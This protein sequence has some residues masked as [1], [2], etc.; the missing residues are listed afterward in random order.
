MIRIILILSLSFIISNSFAQVD[1]ALVIAKEVKERLNKGANFCEMVRLYSED[2]QTKAN[3]GELG[4]FG[5]GQL[6]RPYE[7]AM[8]KLKI[9]QISDIVKTGYGYHIIQL[10]SVEK[11]EYDTRHILIKYR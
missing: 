11:K 2:T 9:G 10:V 7:D 6:V 5:K 1:S 8:V 3:C 4:L